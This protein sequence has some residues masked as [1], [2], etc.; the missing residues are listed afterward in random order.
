[1]LRVP[2]I[3][4]DESG[5]TGPDLGNAGQPVYVVASVLA[6]DS[7]NDF[8]PGPDEGE[9]KWSALAASDEGRALVVRLAHHSTNDRVKTCIADKRYMAVAKMVDE[10]IEPMA[11]ATGFDLYGTDSHRG[12][13]KMTYVALRWLAGDD[14]LESVVTTF[15]AMMRRRDPG[16]I[17]AF[18]RGLEEVGARTPEAGEQ[19]SFIG[20]TE[21]WARRELAQADPGFFE[22]DPAVPLVSSLAAAWSQEL[23]IP[24]RFVHDTSGKLKEWRDYFLHFGRMDTEPSTIRIGEID[25]TV[26]VLTFELQLADSASAPLIQIA[27]VLAGATRYLAQQTLFDRTDAF[28]EALRCAPVANLAVEALWFVPPDFEG[29]G[30]P[31]PL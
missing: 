12:I 4:L 7:W 1:M 31:S 30:P 3:Y 9:L 16:S 13:T 25:I 22:L 5:N 18:Y 10:L 15:V 24:H 11:T 14:G 19:L 29:A 2:E 8:L 26:P 23:G 27:D 6:D 20:L 17:D 28:T 21:E